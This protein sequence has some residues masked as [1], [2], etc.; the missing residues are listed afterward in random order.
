MT[1]FRLDKTAQ[2][3]VLFA[4]IAT[5]C[6]E[7]GSVPLP[8]EQPKPRIGYGLVNAW[9]LS[10]PAPQARA[11]DDAGLGL[12]AIEW[13]PAWGSPID[14]RCSD[15]STHETYP[16]Q[17]RIF[18]ET[19]RA[20]GIETNIIIVNANGCSQRNQPDSYVTTAVEEIRDG[21]GTDMVLLTAVSEPWAYPEKA[22][23]WTRLVAERWPGKLVVPDAGQGHETGRPYW[24]GLLAELV[25]VHY[26]SEPDLLRDLER[27]N[28]GV[29]HT[30][31]CGPILNPGP[32]RAARLAAAAASTDSPLLIYDYRGTSPD[33]AT[34]AAMG[35]AIRPRLAM[36][37]H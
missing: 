28:P 23:H 33:Y 13:A 19:M 34:I 29:L 16:M 6:S 27:G 24:S 11:L 14:P 20:H 21:I 2:T 4:A 1:F 25:D 12:T 22:E 9:H 3:V 18:V 35:E 30:T 37:H 8:T 32:E 7:N 36:H 10:E 15:K 17:A 5:A 26:C 31:D